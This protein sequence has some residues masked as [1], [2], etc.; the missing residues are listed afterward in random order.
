VF[1]ESYLSIRFLIL[2]PAIKVKINM[3][4]RITLWNVVKSMDACFWQ[5]GNV[6]IIGWQLKQLY[7][8]HLSC[9]ELKSPNVVRRFW[10]TNW[11]DSK[12][13]STHWKTLSL[14]CFKR[15]DWI[16]LFPANL[17]LNHL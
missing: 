1:I 5:H 8:P 4:T 14:T 7:S 3:R 13:Q 12:G 11:G 10:L 15:K 9:G 6:S 17:P 16:S 2:V